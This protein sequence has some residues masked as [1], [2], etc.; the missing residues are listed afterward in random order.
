[1]ALHQALLDVLDKCGDI[2]LG[3]IGE[4]CPQAD[5]RL[6]VVGQAE[7][8]QDAQLIVVFEDGRGL[9]WWAAQSLLFLYVVGELA[10][11]L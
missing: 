8:V 5:V 3:R 4:Q 7:L 9:S 6:G 11:G 2:L 1:V 10:E